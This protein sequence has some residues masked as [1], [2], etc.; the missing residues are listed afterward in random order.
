MV[1]KRTNNNEQYLLYNERVS[2]FTITKTALLH[3]LGCWFDLTFSGSESVVVLSTS[4]EAPQTHWYQ[5]RLMLQ[6][7]LAVNATQVGVSIFIGREGGRVCVWG[8]ALD[9]SVQKWHCGF[10][11]E[12][13]LNS[14]T[15]VLRG[16]GSFSRLAYIHGLVWFGLV[17]VVLD[18]VGLGW[19]V[20]ILFSLLLS[21]C[22]IFFFFRVISLS[23]FSVFRCLDFLILGW[24]HVSCPRM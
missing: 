18:W 20:F 19:V 13:I 2:R 6:E 10:N 21:S 4:P 15:V 9:I 24:G 8:V 7:P 11:S 14:T 3:G 17:R 16:C 1:G 5:C 22:F 23:F 12:D